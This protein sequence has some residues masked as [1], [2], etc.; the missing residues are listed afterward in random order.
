ME[1][2]NIKGIALNYPPIQIIIWNWIGEWLN[3]NELFSETIVS[4]YISSQTRL[5]LGYLMQP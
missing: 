2:K 3:S 5:L 4:T 1:T